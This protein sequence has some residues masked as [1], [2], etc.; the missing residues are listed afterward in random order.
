MASLL[1]EY[2]KWNV[3]CLVITF[4]LSLFSVEIA[5]QR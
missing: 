4:N 1:L 5:L 3:M 2:T